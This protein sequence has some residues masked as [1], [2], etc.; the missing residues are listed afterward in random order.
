M[1]SVNSNSVG[2]I[3][4]LRPLMPRT[5]Y[6]FY[7]LFPL[8]FK[9]KEW[10]RGLRVKNYVTTYPSMR[11]FFQCSLHIY[12][13]FTSGGNDIWQRWVQVAETLIA[14]SSSFS[15]REESD[16]L[17]TQKSKSASLKKYICKILCSL[18]HFVESIWFK[19]PQ[20]AKKIHLLPAFP[21]LVF[22]PLMSTQTGF[23]IGAR[24]P[25]GLY[26]W[27]LI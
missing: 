1:T 14:K 6:P 20:S 27:S 11:T 21:Q 26:Y 22:Q 23:M 2:R 25:S 12:T 10:N 4:G 7:T 3:I 19:A 15:R 16:S 24:Q 8:L 17:R 18:W 13:L 9:Q 5:S